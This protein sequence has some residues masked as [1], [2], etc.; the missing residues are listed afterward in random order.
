M[1]PAVTYTG[2]ETVEKANTEANW[3]ANIDAAVSNAILGKI[4]LKEY[5]EIMQKAAKDG[6]N[7]LI[8]IQQNAYDRYLELVK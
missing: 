2:D 7:D 6:Y 5:D 4:T 8:K 1:Y 3:R